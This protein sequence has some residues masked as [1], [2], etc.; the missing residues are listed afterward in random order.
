[1]L[2]LR[3]AVSP[4]SLPTAKLQNL[5]RLQKV[6]G[7]LSLPWSCPPL[8]SGE[9]DMWGTTAEWNTRQFYSS[10]GGLI[11]EGSSPGTLFL[12]PSASTRLWVVGSL[13]H[14]T[15]TL[16]LVGRGAMLHSFGES[17]SHKIH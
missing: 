4:L 15:L 5:L 1:M 16:S 14:W 12:P 13:S 2:W 6:G 3:V 8:W 9:L 10:L 17:R 11:L 7:G